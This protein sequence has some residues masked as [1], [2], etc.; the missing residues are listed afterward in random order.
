MVELAQSTVYLKKD[1]ISD[2][3]PAEE[4]PI[5]ALPYYCLSSDG[6]QIP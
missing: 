3:G 5:S 2:K 6:V 4:R 1:K